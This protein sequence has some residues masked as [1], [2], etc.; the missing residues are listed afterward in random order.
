MV[1][2]YRFVKTYPMSDVILFLT[3]FIIGYICFIAIVLLFG[4]MFFPF[5][6]M[7]EHAKRN[8]RMSLK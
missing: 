8:I 7:E 3:V 6:T 2:L 1:L 5:Y 4:K